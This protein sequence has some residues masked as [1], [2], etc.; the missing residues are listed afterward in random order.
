MADISQYG[1][2]EGKVWHFNETQIIDDHE[3]DRIDFSQMILPADAPPFEQIVEETVSALMD[4][5]AEHTDYDGY[6][7][8]PSQN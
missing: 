4:P 1:Y 8:F 5:E 2:L 3:I 6:M 7:Q